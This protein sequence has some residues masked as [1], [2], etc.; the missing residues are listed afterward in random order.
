M[1]RVLFIFRVWEE[2]EEEE[3]KGPEKEAT[4]SSLHIDST[5]TLLSFEGHHPGKLFELVE[6]HA[7]AAA[8]TLF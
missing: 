7:K 4:S 3:E 6:T 1:F 5:T 2:K 8:R